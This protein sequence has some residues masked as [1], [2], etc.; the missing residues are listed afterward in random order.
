MRS[1]RCGKEGTKQCRGQ[2]QRGRTWKCDWR[3]TS[4]K[5]REP[6][7]LEHGVAVAISREDTDQGRPKMQE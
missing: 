5:G 7:V 6:G 4:E 1:G 2:W 3:V